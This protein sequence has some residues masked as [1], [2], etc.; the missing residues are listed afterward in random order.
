[1]KRPF[2][3]TGLTIL[4]RYILKEFLLNLL[5]ILASLVVLFLIV[6][7]FQRIRM[8]ISNSA[9]VGQVAVYFFYS[10]PMILVQMIP[11]SV[12]L[13]SLITFGTFS[14]YC[15]LVALR[16]SGVSLYR[17]ALPPLLS[18]LVI[19]L[20]T[21]LISEFITPYANQRVKHT[22]Y[23]E[24]QNRTQSGTF[25]H[26]EIWYRGK[27]GIYNFAVFD[28]HTN[29]LRGIRINYLDESMNLV[30]R[31]DAAEGFWRN[32]TWVFHRVMI[33]TFPEDDFPHIETRKSMKID[34][35]EKPQDFL[36]VQRE[37]DEMGFGEL[38]RYI[39]K[40][41]SEGYDAGRYLADLHGKAAFPFVSVIM[42]VLGLCFAA[43][44]ERSGGIAQGIGIGIATGL[45]YWLVFA[46]TMSLGRSGALPPVIGAWAANILFLAASIFLLRR[47]RT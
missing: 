36:V 13:S 6:D 5:L 40:I 21:F 2:E 18:A 32:G 47:I 4:D 43:R 19:A 46:F 41:R 31:I 12:L 34:I 26:H 8:F 1:M 44:S 10:I 27:P 38:R 14:R 45:S 23:V 30:K 39:T 25:K 7:F 35:P 11:V 16:A 24:I 3:I 28:P 22:K 15:E 37:P 17:A 29:V 33:A 9:T 42:A 20:A